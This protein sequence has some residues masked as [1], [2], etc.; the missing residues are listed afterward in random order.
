MIERRDLERRAAQLGIAVRHVELDYVLHHLLA[1]FGPDPDG[2][3]FRGGTALAR[4]Y[5]PDY[6]ISEDLDFIVPGDAPDLI[7]TVDAVVMRVAEKTG[8]DVQLTTVGWLDDRLR[9]NV[10]WTT[11]H[12]G[13]GDVIIDVV[14]RQAGLPP[15]TRPLHLRYPDLDPVQGATIRVL[16]LEEILANKWTMLGDRQEPRDLFDLYWG[17]VHGVSFNAIALAHQAVYRYPLML[18]S[19][20]G[21]ARLESR[22]EQRLRHQMHDLPPFRAALEE[23]RRQ[24]DAWR[25][26]TT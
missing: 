15:V 23:L 18:A 9:A 20:E 2:L 1:G 17:L 22:W 26:S 4:V 5:W 21:A 25:S 13:A 8:F 10:T 3:I 11:G 12:S 24:F 14:R 19:V 6:R 7:D 16:E